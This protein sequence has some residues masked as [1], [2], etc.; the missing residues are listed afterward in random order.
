MKI[1]GMRQTLILGNITRAV[2]WERPFVFKDQI[3]HEW[4]SVCL[5]GGTHADRASFRTHLQALIYARQHVEDAH[6]CVSTQ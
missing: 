4:T 6:A 1:A 5:H 2:R 3:T